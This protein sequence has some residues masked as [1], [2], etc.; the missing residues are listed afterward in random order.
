MTTPPPLHDRR[1]RPADPSADLAV[2]IARLHEAFA[3]VAFD[4]DMVRSRGIVTDGEVDELG[5]PVAGLDAGLVARFVLKAGTSW[6]GPDD[7][8]RVAPRALELAAD[9]ALAVDR[10][11]LWSKLRRAGWPAW[12]GSQVDAV[13]AFLRAEWVRLL[14][15]DPR[16]AHTAHRWLRD[17]T[18]GVDDLLPFL[19]DWHD[20]L[21]PLTPPPHHRAAAC[22]L[23]ALLV[24]S[25]LR[26]DHP[27]T[28]AEV[29]GPDA[30][31]TTV[32]QLTTWLTGP[33][34]AHELRRAAEALAGTRDARRV[35]LAVERLARFSA[36]VDRPDTTTD[37]D[38]E[39]TP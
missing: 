6:G 22:H 24:D 25:P 1:Y 19:D 31:P 8:R 15:S 23:V 32:Q 13:H 12:P 14:R 34:T 7:L 5:G 28:V 20:A 29:L 3:G 4:V 35:A 36:A 37:T 11:V 27:A 2:A 39:T 30:P 17:L 9:H 10:T 26:P 38:T 21:G 33:G 18:A 16:P